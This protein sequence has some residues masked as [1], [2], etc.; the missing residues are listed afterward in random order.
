MPDAATAPSLA[1][2]QRWVLLAVF[3]FAIAT[4]A[5]DLVVQPGSAA[6]GGGFYLVQGDKSRRVWCTAKGA[7]GQA[8]G[9]Q[10]CAMSQPVAVSPDGCRI[11]FDAKPA[12]AI[13]NGFADAPTVKV[14]TLCEPKAS[15][16]GDASARRKTAH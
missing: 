9:D 1:P 7:P 3:T 8:A 5:G 15:G 10:A 13:A 2:R 11:A 6:N 4:Q 14:M 12:A 16:K